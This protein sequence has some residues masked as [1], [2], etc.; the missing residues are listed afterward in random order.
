MARPGTPEYYSVPLATRQRQYQVASFS[1][2]AGQAVPAS[3][4]FTQREMEYVRAANQTTGGWAEE[5]KKKYPSYAGYLAIPEIAQVLQMATESGMQP[6]E[7]LSR[8]QTTQWWTSHNDTQR[9][10]F[11]LNHTD[12]ASA[13]QALMGQLGEVQ[14]AA[15]KFGINVSPHILTG[16][17]T[18]ALANGWTDEQIVESLVKLQAESGDAPS[19]M[20]GA[21]YDQVQKL[22]NDY[23]VPMSDRGLTFHMRQLALGKETIEGLESYLRD[24]A[25]SLFRDDGIHKALDS[26]MTMREYADPYVQLAAQ[27]LNINPADID[28]GKNRWR[29]AL[30]FSLPDG[31]KRAM[32]L[33]EW[34][35]E[36]RTN[37]QYG[38][39]HTNQAVDQAAQFSNELL[40]KF[41]RVA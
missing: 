14:R 31:T 34:G 40:K 36:L 15:A 22:S 4:Y 9:Q 18:N 6:P 20:L 3:L 19:G 12:P 33:D 32:S 25:K 35:S 28:M 41:G 27:T 2:G 37:K 17:A 13:A 21:T 29:R 30:Q 10:W 5:A 1:A 24:Q 23:M 7:L 39:D 11:L 38:F 8:L 16:L 26:G